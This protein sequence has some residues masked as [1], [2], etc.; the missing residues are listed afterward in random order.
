MNLTSLLQT[1]PYTLL[2]G[3]TD[4]EITGLCCSSREAGPGSLF[5]CLSGARVDG[6]DFAPQAVEQG[7]AALVVEHPVEVSEGVTV[8]Q[9]EDGRRALALVSAAFYGY[10]ARSLTTIGVTGTK[11]KTTVSGMIAQILEHAGHPTCLIGT[12]GISFAGQFQ[13]TDNT[14]PE[15]HLIH[16]ALRQAVDAGCT[17][18][19]MEVSSQATKLSRVAGM[20]FD[21]GVFTN[22]SPDHIGPAE[23]P[24]FDDYLHHK[25]LLFR[26][27]R[28]GIVNGEDEHAQAI[29]EGNTCEE[30][31][32]YGNVPDSG[33]THADA[34]ILRRGA[35][36]AVEY[37]LSGRRAAQVL[38]NLPGDFSV[39]NSLAATAVCDHMGIAMEDIL[40]ALEKLCIPGRLERVEV[41]GGAS[42][43][44]DY[45]HNGFS[46]ETLLSTLRRYEPKRLFC[47]FGAGGNRDPHR[48]WEMGRAAG[49]WADYVVVTTDNPRYEDPKAI[50][51]D[52]LKGVLEVG[53][54]GI[55]IEDRA[56]A[57]RFCLDHAEPGDVIVMAG[58]GHERYVEIQGKK[59]HFTERDAIQKALEL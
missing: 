12:V 22:L 17:H 40:G 30:A 25:A 31:L 46:L 45:A 28:V 16:R 53:A 49:K 36:L 26:Q 7:A 10:P 35:D 24:D 4:R 14:T 39:M 15:S 51:L 57:V 33:W 43:F 11:G 2:Q 42:L 3:E 56:K 19:V 34:H 32:F 5:F 59:Y 41:P 29:L 44:I 8:I 20:E 48:R 47:L 52:C 1:I 6:H 23:H 27:C 37:Q 55:A 18:L 21:Y 58:K 54:T 50:I 38:V 9:V 13:P